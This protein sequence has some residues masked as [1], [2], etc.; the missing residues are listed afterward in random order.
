MEFPDLLGTREEKTQHRAALD[1]V[2]WLLKSLD[3][4]ASQI[5]EPPARRRSR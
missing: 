3:T 2:Q 1:A 4:K 5:T